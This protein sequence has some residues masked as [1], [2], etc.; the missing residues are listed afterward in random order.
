MAGHSRVEGS[1]RADVL[2]KAGSATLTKEPGPF[3]PV[4]ESVCMKELTEWVK[5]RHAETILRNQMFK[6]FCKIL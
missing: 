5:E 4:P 2:T 6:N 1:E 3:L